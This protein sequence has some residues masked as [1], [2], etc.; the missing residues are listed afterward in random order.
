MIRTWA[1]RVVMAIALMGIGAALQ[2]VPAQGRPSFD[3]RF[4]HLGFVVRD[5]EQSAQR[6]ARTF[7]ATPTPIHTLDG[8]AFPKNAA[9]RTSTTIKTTEIR[10][11]AL[12]MHL[13]EPVGGSSPWM[14]HLQAHGDGS[15]EHLSF[16]VTDLAA[17]VRSLE[18]LGGTVIVGASDSFFAYVAFPGLPFAIEL[19]K[20]PK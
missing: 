1:A 20:V 6:F 12:E 2:S 7:G 3:G 17:A 5:V 4:R 15:L 18:A 16:G 9:G 8:V 10:T 19:E 11:H 13:L 14:D